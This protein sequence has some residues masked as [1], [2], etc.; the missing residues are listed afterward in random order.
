MR[1]LFSILTAAILTAGASAAFAQEPDQNVTDEQRAEAESL[2]AEGRKL[3]TDKKKLNEACDTLAKSYEIQKRGD[4]LLNLAECHRRQGKTATA[5]R[6][7]DEAIKYAKEV[8]FTEAIETAE[9]LRDQLAVGLSQLQVDVPVPTPE[10]EELVVI[11]DGKPLPW[12]QWGD[13]LFV[14]PGL[15]TVSASAKGYVS[16]DSS[17][18]V[19]EGAGRTT[20]T[21]RLEKVPEPPKPP[22]KVEPKPE[23]KPVPKPPQAEA[24]LPIWAIVVGSTG[25]AM[26]GV[27]IGFGV[28]V[29]DV[30][31]E[32]DD[33]CLGEARNQCPSTY[34]FEGAYAHEKR[35]F[36]LFVG[37][38]A[39]GIAATAVG[40]IG[41]GLGLSSSGS[42]K[43]ALPITVLPWATAEGAGVVVG[44]AL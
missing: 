13:P 43:A 30:G 6:E 42:D 14:D 17:A 35:S 27:S 2:F 7:F 23:P 31:G 1:R 38:G 18:E 25:V 3:L 29:L 36:G 24:S 44:G 40:A 32:L 19:K 39:A 4:T 37:F 10:P 9:R 33:Q 22:A 21:V 11:L 28:D 41:L 5:W 26:M 15:H 34:D 12:V 16:F 8:Q 20:I